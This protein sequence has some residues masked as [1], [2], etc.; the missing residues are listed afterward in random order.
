MGGK[1]KRHGEHLLLFIATGVIFFVMLTG[2]MG[3]TKKTVMSQEADNTGKQIPYLPEGFVSSEQLADEEDDPDCFLDDAALSIQ[4]G[5]CKNALEM[6]FFAVSCCE[7]CG[8]G[9]FNRALHL[10]AVAL[11]HPDCYPGDSNKT[12]SFF[13]RLE[14][15]FPDSVKGRPA[16]SWL[17]FIEDVLIQNE[18]CS[19]MK[20]KLASHLKKIRALESQIEQLKAVDF[21]LET[22]KTGELS[23]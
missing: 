11:S 12:V 17:N 15:S 1:H 3:T 16:R 21:E 9:F 13:L 19:V 23:P 14:S 20:D 6:I 4:Q 18:D 8:E 7:N 10:M 2:C 22:S 5:E